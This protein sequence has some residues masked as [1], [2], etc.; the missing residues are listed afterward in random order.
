MGDCILIAHMLV[1]FDGKAIHS[2]PGEIQGSAGSIGGN[3]LTEYLNMMCRQQVTAPSARLLTSSRM[4]RLCLKLSGKVRH[5]SY[6]RMMS[7]L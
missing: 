7:V 3:G 6:S 5:L 2:P 1:L 4:K